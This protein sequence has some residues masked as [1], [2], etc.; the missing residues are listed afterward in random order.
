MTK[1]KIFEKILAQEELYIEKLEQSLQQYKSASN[2]EDEGTMDRHDMSQANEAKDM[3]LRLRVQL[4]KAN[5]D[6]TEFKKVGSKSYDSVEAG[7]LVTTE[8]SYFFVGVS[9]HTITID[10]K[11]VY[12][13]S[14][15][16]PAFKTMY[17]KEK[18][19]EFTLG[20]TTYK[21]QDIS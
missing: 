13:V 14:A 21:I 1:E 5:G 8:K 4:D 19:D 9:L 6:L 18:N 16:S 12:G 10:G 11:E 17:G 2:L 20:D 15:E 3:Q 7:A